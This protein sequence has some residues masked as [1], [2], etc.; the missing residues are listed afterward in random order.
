MLEGFIFCSKPCLK[1]FISK[2]D[3]MKL[4]PTF[5]EW[6]AMDQLLHGWIYI[7]LTAEIASQVIGCK[8]S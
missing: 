7:T 8:T 5:E 1:K 2:E 6:T 4:N 3:E